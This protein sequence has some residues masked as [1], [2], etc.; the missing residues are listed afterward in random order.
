MDEKQ[1]LNWMINY[2]LYNEET[3]LKSIS[4]IRKYRS[5]VINYNYGL[6]LVKQFVEAKAGDRKDVKKQWAVFG[7]LLSNPVLPEDLLIK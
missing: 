3:G 1:A 2:C 7:E 5:Y 6:D 4:F